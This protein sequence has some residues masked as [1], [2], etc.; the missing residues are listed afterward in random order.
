VVRSLVHNPGLVRSLRPAHDADALTGHRWHVRGVASATPEADDVARRFSQVMG[1]A[2]A[3]EV[4]AQQLHELTDAAAAA[5]PSFTAD[6]V[7]IVLLSLAHLA[8]DPGTEH[9]EA[10]KALTM[11]V[12]GGYGNRGY[13]MSFPCNPHQPM[14]RLVV[15]GCHV[16]FPTEESSHCRAQPP[17]SVGVRAERA[18]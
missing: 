10:A 9:E 5:L 12:A 6:H 18:S 7:S 17:Q 15:Q 1:R 14:V 2:S 13:G 4:S 3:G 8:H 16:V 11:W